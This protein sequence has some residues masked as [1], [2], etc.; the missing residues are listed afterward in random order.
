MLELWGMRSIPSLPLLPGTIWPVV[1]APDQDLIYGLTR[2]KLCTYAK[3]NCVLTLK[4]YTYTKLN[5]LK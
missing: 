4:L 3:L 2:S 5:S 1:V